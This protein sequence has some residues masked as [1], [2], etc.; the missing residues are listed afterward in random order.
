MMFAAI[1]VAVY[2]ALGVFKKKKKKSFWYAVYS[3]WNPL[4]ESS[5]SW[6]DSE[7]ERK[8]KEIQRD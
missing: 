8:R 6:K 7:G 1:N 2:K 5:K 3:P 4:I